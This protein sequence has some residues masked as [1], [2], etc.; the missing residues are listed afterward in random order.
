MKLL[1]LL[2]LALIATTSA[3]SAIEKVDPIQYIDPMIG[4][5]S[6]SPDHR[7]TCGRTF[8]GAATP[9]G[10]L[11]VSPDTFTGLDNAAGYSD[12][13]NSMEG[14]SWMHL[15][16]IGAAGEFGNFLVMPSTGKFF[17]NKGKLED[18]D[19]GFRSRYSHETE[20]ASAGY[21][22]V[23][24]DDYDVRAELTTK[25]RAGLMR[26]TFPESDT[27]RIQIDFSRRMGGRATRQAFKVVSDRAIEGWVYCDSTGG[28]W[29][30][31]R[32]LSEDLAYKV[33]IYLEFDRPFV[34][35][36]AWSA[37][38]PEGLICRDDEMNS[39]EFRERVKNSKI[40]SS[41][42]QLEGD[43]IGF[44][45]EFATEEGDQVMIKAGLSFV[46]QD[47]AKL[48]LE[49]DLPH[50]DFKQVR[51]EAEDMWRLAADGLYIKGASEKQKEI[52]YT[53]MYHMKIDPRVFSDVDGRYIGG[54]G[55]IHTTK[56]FTYRTVFSGWDVFRSLFPLLTI[57]D[58]QIVDDEVQ[59]LI[60]MATLAGRG[61][62]RWELLSQY[63]SCM[64]GEPA[65][66]VILDAYRK[67]IRNYD[68]EVAYQL[69][70]T[71]TGGGDCIRDG[72]VEYNK[73]GYVPPSVSKK[74]VSMSLE[75][76]FAEW[77]M[78]EWAKDLGKTEDMEFYADRAQNYRKLF[79]PKH[80]WML[81]KN[82]AGEFV[83]KWEGKLKK[84]N[85]GTVESNTFQQTWF[86]P[87]D[88]QGLVNLMGAERFE[89][90]LIEL[91]EG[92]PEDYTY[93]DHYNHSNEPVH[94]VPYLFAYIG[95]P[96]LTQKYV[97]DIMDKA[98]GLGPRGLCGNEDVGQMS[99]WFVFSAM[100]F[101]PVAPGDNVYV[102][103]SPLFEEMTIRLNSDYHSGDSFT[104]I[105]HNNSSENIYIQSVKLNGQP[106]KRAW[107][108][109]EEV[110]AGGQLEFEMGP[111]PNKRF[112]AD[113]KMFPP[114]MSN[115]N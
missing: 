111:K 98:Y 101:H 104:V 40:I 39:D 23:T 87:H 32:R 48:N 5:T 49:T 103:G 56:N 19:G 97:R 88:V 46:S 84:K 83:G 107:I 102:L 24:L 31:G 105:A 81:P 96:W 47:N 1:T 34:R 36:G 86:V 94:H 95:K 64:V 16:G 90:E 114:S 59:S 76:T 44:F 42:R 33:Y 29:M 2:S 91:F 58:P 99:A 11:Q 66:P 4:A 72:W 7:P 77:C 8:P 108:W 30:H 28:G 74:C 100:G 9:F 41:P 18:P 79:D 38:V 61:Y 53:A 70:K 112:G 51:E 57:I 12:H 15:S 78:Y 13:H 3:I 110:A 37:E 20:V 109:H 106:L 89:E 17:P 115:Q 69:G 80:G 67:G 54:D 62:P 63:T 22:A 27:S 25:P 45:T 113:P 82:E 35:T 26:F 73:Y 93:N 50:W 85:H 14:F 21:Y 65:L 68:V 52:F 10:M 60:E 6:Q 92:A 75:N 71:T 43:H 55:E